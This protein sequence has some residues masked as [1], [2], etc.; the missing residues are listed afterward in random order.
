M[1]YISNTLLKQAVTIGEKQGF[2]RQL[3]RDLLN[4]LRS[5][6]LHAVT[7]FMIHRYAS[8]KPCD[9]HV[10]V[11]VMLH[12]NGQDAPIS[13]CVDMTIDF[14]NRLPGEGHITAEM[15][16][17]DAS[18]NVAVERTLDY[19]RKATEGQ[20]VEVRN[21]ALNN[22]LRDLDASLKRLGAA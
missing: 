8:G 15:I 2:N 6:T 5:N 19:V 11:T 1:K 3:D 14:F 22:H 4:D 12:L 9:P 16:R 17:A 18:R 21:T 10:R 7:P 13:E 20:P